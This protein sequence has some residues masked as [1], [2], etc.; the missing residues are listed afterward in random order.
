MQ[1]THRRFQLATKYVHGKLG[2]V[3]TINVTLPVRWDKVRS[4]FRPTSPPASRLDGWLGQAPLIPYC[5]ERCHGFF[6]R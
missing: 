3:H 2:K 1:R 4:S 6:R 5:P